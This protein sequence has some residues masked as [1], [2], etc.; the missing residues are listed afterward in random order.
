MLKKTLISFAAGAAVCATLGL[1]LGFTQPE[2]GQPA[3]ENW[4]EMSPEQMEAMFA[5]MAEKATPGAHHEK[6]AD[7]IGHW[8]VEASFGVGDDAMTGTGTME[9][10][11]ILGGRYTYADFKLDDF[12]GQPFHGVAINGYSNYTNE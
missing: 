12:M 1:S 8:T 10:K 4:Q 5:E 11:W 6:L 3:E 9:V 2:E 7:L